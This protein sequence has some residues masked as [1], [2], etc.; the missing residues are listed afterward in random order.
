MSDNAS[1]NRYRFVPASIASHMCLGGIFAW[2][3]FNEPIT[4][5]HG[6]LVPAAADWTL[7][8]TSV[9][10][11]LVMGG[12]VWGAFAARYFESWGPR[13]CTSLGALS[14]GLGFGMASTAIQ[15]SSLPLLYAGGAVWGLSLAWSYVP[16]VGVLL[17]WFPDRKGFA[18]GGW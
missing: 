12:F 13:A 7:T 8:Q 5:V 2:S 16:P 17:K 4:R 1:V 6:V 18:A 15:L 3:V 14:L 10:F 9:T 11:S